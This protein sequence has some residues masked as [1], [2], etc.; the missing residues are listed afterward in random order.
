MA[1]TP[2]PTS[3]KVTAATVT[4]SVTTVVMY[5]VGQVPY[6]AAFPDDVKLAVL[7]IVTGLVTYVAGY[8][9]RDPLRTWLAVNH[10]G[11]DHAA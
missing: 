5:L 6:V 7:V 10:P 3:P 2:T 8:L 9:R 1:E 4:A 11:G